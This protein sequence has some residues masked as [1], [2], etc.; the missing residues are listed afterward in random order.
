MSS[1]ECLIICFF[2]NLPLLG[3]RSFNL[4]K[5]NDKIMYNTWKDACEKTLKFVKD[6][7]E[8]LQI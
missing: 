4:H 2:E 3:L 1:N 8:R 5:I 7:D 6:H